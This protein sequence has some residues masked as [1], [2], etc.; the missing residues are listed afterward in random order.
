M[1]HLE[2]G[3]RQQQGVGVRQADIFRR[4]DAQAPGDEEGILAPLEHPGQVIHRRVGIGAAHAL[5][6]G[7][8]DIVM[9][10]A[11]FVVDGH[12]LL[13]ALRD[14]LVVDDDGGAAG[15]GVHHDLQDIQQL[16]GVAG[17]ETE[18][19]VGFLDGDLLVF[20]EGVRLDSSIKK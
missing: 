4:Q 20:Q 18:E 5:D 8:Y 17:A 12:I 10:L 9:H 13:Q 2:A 16:A 19:R 14:M 11:A 3:I 6:E 1:H 15:R 7:R